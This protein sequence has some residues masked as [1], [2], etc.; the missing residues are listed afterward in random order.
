MLTQKSSKF[1]VLRI[2]DGGLKLN[3]QNCYSELGAKHSKILVIYPL[4]GVIKVFSPQSISLKMHFI[5]PI[6][7]IMHIYVYKESL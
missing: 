6:E 2:K 5:K 4:F 1:L 3:V 7:A